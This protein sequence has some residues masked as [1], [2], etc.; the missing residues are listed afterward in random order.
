M[1]KKI[2]F[3]LTM[4]DDVQVRDLEELKEHFDIDKAIGYFLDGKLLTWLEARYYD[5]EA[6]AVR[7]LN[8]D[9]ADVHRRLCDIFGVEYHAEDAPAIDVEAVAERNRR[10]TELKQYTS[11]AKILEKI[12]HVAFDQEE[13]A[14]L[15][16]D[17]VH[18]IYLCNNS[19]TIPLRVEN[20]R[21]IGVGK[22]EAV[23]RSIEEVDFAAKGIEF[24]NVKF[25][26]EYENFAK[27]FP[28]RVYEQG[29]EAENRKDYAKAMEL[30][31][32]GAEVGHSGCM[33]K[34]GVLNDY[35]L[36]VNQNF[37]EAYNWYVK[38][39]ELGN[40]DAMNNIGN[41]YLNGYGVAQNY[42]EALNWYHKAAD[43]GNSRAMTNIGNRYIRGE[44]V[45]QNVDEG[46]VWCEKAA[47]LGYVN[48]M[49][50]HGSF[51]WLEKAVDL[52]SGRAARE[53]GLRL[54]SIKWYTKAVDLGDAE[55][56]YD[57]AFEY[58]SYGSKIGRNC[59]EA[60]K[61]A[62]KGAEMGSS[63]AMWLLAILFELGEGTVKDESKAVY[64]M[65]E[66][67]DR[68]H[69]SALNE[70][71]EWYFYGKCGLPKDENEASKWRNMAN[72]MRKEGKRYGV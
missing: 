24:E 68:G 11:E 34:I 17:G 48:A 35:G 41:L 2:K 4:K 51:E 43:L 21:Y 28:D 23:I 29:Q 20:T 36:G 58:W 70:L 18:E 42:T 45:T 33:Y 59:S 69:E 61:W 67:A 12:D 6:D 5:T 19:F 46:R 26:A 7:S 10:L 50:A 72:R 56:A 39:S 8:K 22:V 44:G 14:D 32:K 63:S 1:A 62:K 25:D 30:Y 31:Q 66:A 9:D 40:T 55:A 71:V 38:A 47:N 37:T 52:G 15:L 54:D 3:P 60:F 64:W 65:K 53:L 13:L 49:I 16:D 57:L 27:N